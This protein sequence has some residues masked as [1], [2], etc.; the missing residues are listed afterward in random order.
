MVSVSLACRKQVLDV[1]LSEYAHQISNSFLSVTFY[2]KHVQ[3][4]IP[5]FYLR[6]RLF[7]GS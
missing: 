7:M 6:A 5:V 2:L 4:H 3:F 1:P